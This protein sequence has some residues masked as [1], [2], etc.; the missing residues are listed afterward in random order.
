MS[1]PMHGAAIQLLDLEKRYGDVTALAGVSLDMP[2]GEFV[3]LLGP[4]GSGKTTTLNAIAG[5]LQPDNGRILVDRSPIETVPPHRRNI[6]MVFQNYALFPHMTVEA[7]IAYPLKRRKVAKQE[8]RRLVAESLALVGLDGMDKRYPRELSGG[9]QQRVALARALVFRPRVL[10]MDEPL[11]AL[12]RRLR[13]SL[14]L[15]FKRIHREL[16]I[17]FVYV[18][19]DQ[20]EALVMSDR[21]AV[22]NN[23]TIDQ[24]GTAEELY[25]RPATL[26]VAEFLGDS[27]VLPGVITDGASGRR[28][29]G[30]GY[31]LTLPKDATLPAGSRGVVTVRPERVTVVPDTP[32]AAPVHGN[33]LAGRVKQAIYMGGIRRLEIDVAGFTMIAQE[34][35]GSG[36]TVAAGDPV[37]ATWDADRSVMLPDVRGEATAGAVTGSLEEV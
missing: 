22:F 11:G 17:T 3:T 28:L 31:E 36:S 12:D 19:H 15:E 30:D 27:N 7:N 8:L 2:A 37:L 21:I 34:Q 26:F 32:T 33:A 24:V 23:G 29:R 16:G 20:D 18:T 6:G 13:A 10:L 14:Q 25:E 1:E 9:Q 4:S 5:F 35:A